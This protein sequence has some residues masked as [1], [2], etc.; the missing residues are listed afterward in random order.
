MNSP[1]ASVMKA[2]PVLPT[3]VPAIFSTRKSIFRSRERFPANSLFSPYKGALI[4]TIGLPVFFD[5]ITVPKFALPSF[6]PLK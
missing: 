5:L 3:L 1:L 2:Y 4:G 6:A